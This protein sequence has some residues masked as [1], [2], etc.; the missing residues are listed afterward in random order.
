TVP[1]AVI[2]A[3]VGAAAGGRAIGASAGIVLAVLWSVAAWWTGPALLLRA[4]RPELADP[5][6]HARL[7]NLVAG[8]AGSA[9]AP[10]PQLSGPRARRRSRRRRPHEVSTRTGGRARQ[11]SSRW[12]GD[13]VPH[14]RASLARS[15]ARRRRPRHPSA[16]RRADRSTPGALNRTCTSLAGTSAP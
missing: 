10:A 8:L 14:D 1:L 4:V 3:G 2:V 7:Y 9:G 13:R 16:A 12:P 11:D 5:E 15:A 6:R